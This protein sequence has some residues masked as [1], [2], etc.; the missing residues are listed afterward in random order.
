[1]EKQKLQT[2]INPKRRRRKKNRKP[3]KLEGSQVYLLKVVS[4]FMK[5]WSRTLRFS[6]ESDVQAV[7]KDLSS[8]CIAVAWHNRLFAVPEFYTRYAESRKLAVIVSASSAGAWLAK[9]FEQMGIHPIRGSRTRRGTQAFNE[10]F[11]AIQS[12]YDVGITPDGSR[13]P[14]YDMKAG[15]GMLALRSKAP[16][17]LFS[18]NFKHA[19]RLKTWDHF[20]IPFPFSRVEVKIDRINYE[21]MPAASE[22]TRDITDMLKARLAAITEDREYNVTCSKSKSEDSKKACC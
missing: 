11:K 12:G 21:D 5:L 8:P 14:M 19:W 16:I 3:R 17:M 13:G 15:A 6:F 10:M 7:I 2:S 18:Y 22:S 1:M 20:Y 9:L 4:L